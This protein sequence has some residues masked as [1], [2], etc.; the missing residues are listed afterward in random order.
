MSKFKSF[1]R[2][3]LGQDT[4]GYGPS[5]LQIMT[6]ALESIWHLGRRA[7]L[8]FAGIAAGSAAVVALINIGNMAQLESASVFKGMGS[9]LLIANLQPSPGQLPTGILPSVFNPGALK[10]KLPGAEQVAGIVM[11]SHE[12]TGAGGTNRVV[13]IGTAGELRTIMGLSLKQGRFLGRAD[14]DSTYVVLG[15]NVAEGRHPGDRIRFGDYVYEVVGILAERGS[16]PLF[17][18]N[19]DNAVFLSAS[20]MKRLVPAPY[21][22]AV[23]VRYFRD[24]SETMAGELTAELKQVRPDL[25][26]SVE[27]PDSLLNGMDQQSRLFGW[28]LLC[29]GAISLLVGGIGVMNVMMMNVAERKKEIGIRLA[30]GARTRDIAC[31]FL[32][33]AV[34]LSVIGAATGCLIG[35]GGAGLFYSFSDWSEF[36]LTVFSL[37]LGAG[38]S[39]ATGLFF[40][41][42][43]AITAAKVEPVRA[44]NDT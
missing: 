15:S 20:G 36:T 24:S 43:P 27:I 29:M 22:T 35:I 38:S 12:F 25:S 42:Y 39:V 11:A 26:V 6:S 8:A 17:P 23:I 34:V 30:L 44:L 19:P 21:L 28:L 10:A 31:Q 18:F 5:F 7:V 1:Y 41:L 14:A 37:I 13:V 16:N 4:S 3:S 32:L 2:V 9:N 40:G 33:E